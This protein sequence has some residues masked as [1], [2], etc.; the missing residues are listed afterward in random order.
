MN[1]MNRLIN[2][3]L[4]TQCYIIDLLPEQVPADSKGQFFKVEGYF[5]KEFEQYG[6]CGRYIRMI[7]KLMCYFPVSIYWKKWAEQPAPEKVA[8]IVHKIMKNQ[9]GT[10]YVLFPVE[11]ALLVFDSGLHMS[12]YNPSVELKR[13]LG[14]TAASEGLFFRKSGS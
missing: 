13:L 6:L 12:V 7:L 11:N 1:K 14:S 2:E 10:L 8:R 5:L 3:L 9:S 4:E